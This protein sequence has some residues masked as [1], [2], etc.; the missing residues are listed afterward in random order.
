MNLNN[1]LMN[2]IDKSPTSYH[3]VEN[4][5]KVLT[6]AFFIKLNENEAWDLQ[7]GKNYFVTRND[8]SIIAFRYTDNDF[9]S[10]NIVSSHSDSPCFKLKENF[11]IGKN[12]NYKSINIE[13]YGSM[14]MSSWMD[15]PLSVAGR[16]QILTE[17]GIETKTVNIDEDLLLIPNIAV[18][19][20]RD[21][22][23]GFKYNPQ[24]HMLPILGDGESNLLKI[25]TNNL[26][27][28]EGD[29]VSHDLFLYVREKSKLI[30]DKEQYLSAPRIDNI[31]NAFLSVKALIDSNNI[32]SIDV[33]AVFDNEEVGS[34]TK[35]GAAST[36][37]FDT[38]KRICEISKKTEED[39]RI[40]LANSFMISA[41]NAHA[42]HP[43]FMEKFDVSNRNYPN[44]G[45]VIKF[46]ANQ[47][48]TTDSVSASVFKMICKKENIPFQTFHNRSDMSGGSTLGSILN[49]RISVRTVDIGI[50]QF[51]MHSAVET[52][53]ALD[54]ELMYKALR[55]FFSL[56]IN[57][58]SNKITF[59]E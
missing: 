15:R 51:A 52:C 58:S 2:F 18:H 53:G 41:D 6:D 59:K 26:G 43:N 50:A 17:N 21:I 25:I 38:F 27:C 55:K 32:D 36:F 34:S 57:F 4:I 20:S 1:E 28:D 23:D 19:L 12:E 56:K 13:P 16:V 14:I 48:Y 37:M 10:F 42:A 8:S 29:V 9:D 5:S 40:I 47:R 3:V 46:N 22:N 45:P 11:D 44:K 49:T 39:F 33:M 24:V 35:Q 7:K 30:G 31:Q 54:S